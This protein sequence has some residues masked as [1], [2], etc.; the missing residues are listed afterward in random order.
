MARGFYTQT[1][2]WGLCTLYSLPT[3][4]SWKVLRVDFSQYLSI[5]Y[6]IYISLTNCSIVQL[7]IVQNPH[8]NSLLLNTASLGVQKLVPRIQ[9]AQG[10]IILI[11]HPLA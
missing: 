2:L 3:Y 4:M 11:D 6:L 9:L 8:L 7:P 10:P 1:R 5:L